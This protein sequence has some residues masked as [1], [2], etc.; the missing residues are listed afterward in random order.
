M[1]LIGFI[2][3][4]LESLLGANTADISPVIVTVQAKPLVG[5]SQVV[6]QNTLSIDLKSAFVSENVYT[7]RY[8][9][10]K[11]IVVAT[12]IFLQKVS[13]DNKEYNSVP[14]YYNSSD[15]RLYTPLISGHYWAVSGH[16][17]TYI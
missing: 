8:N 3:T 15:K 1:G 4:K 14:A 11:S 12:A 9:V 16:K 17:L 2:N 5:E 13:V 10:E 7:F 6:C